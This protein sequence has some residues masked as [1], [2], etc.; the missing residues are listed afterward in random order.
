LRIIMRPGVTSA[1]RVTGFAG[2]VEL[3]SL[4]KIREPFHL[5]QDF[6]QRS[7]GAD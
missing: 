3:A 5:V 2:K 1:L 7:P 6:R 4:A